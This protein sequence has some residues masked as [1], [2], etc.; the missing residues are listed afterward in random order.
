MNKIEGTVEVGPTSYKI[1]KAFKCG[2]SLKKTAE[3]LQISRDFVKASARKM[4]YRNLI[5]DGDRQGRREVYVDLRR[6]KIITS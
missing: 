2:M 3:H 4:R 1:L 5:G 6:T